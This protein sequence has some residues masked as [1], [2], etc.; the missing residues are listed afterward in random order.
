MNYSIAESGQDL[1]VAFQGRFTHADTDRFRALLCLLDT[2][3]RLRVTCDF[4]GLDFIDSSA[5][6]MLLT[7][8]QHPA[9]SGQR[10][11]L[12]GLQGQVERLIGLTRFSEIFVIKA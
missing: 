7:L 1:V 3:R 4:K 10:V 12:R 2:K 9:L 8:N 6:G 5:L 11:T